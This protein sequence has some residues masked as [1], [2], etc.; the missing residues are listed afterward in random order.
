[1]A[2][3]LRDQ[4]IQEVEDRFHNLFRMNIPKI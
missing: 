1:M 3:I 2:N 4:R